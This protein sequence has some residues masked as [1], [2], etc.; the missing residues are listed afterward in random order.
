MTKSTLTIDLQAI[1]DN[2]RALDRMTKAE[3]AAVVKADSYGLGA[4][5]V[6]KT[7]AEAGARQFFVALTEEGVALRQALGE[8]PVINVFSGHMAGDAEAI[9]GAALTPM[10]NSTEQLLRQLETLP[11]HAFGIQLD[12]GMN[13]LGM[14]PAEWAALRDIALSQNPRLIMSHLACSDAPDHEMNDAQLRS[15]SDMTQGVEVPRS[16]SATGG[17]LLGPEYHFDVTRPGIGLY[18]GR[19]F[20]EARPVVILDVPV[21]QTRSVTPG[22]T[23]GYGNTWTAESTVKLATVAAG[24]ADGLLRAMG[25]ATGTACFQHE[26]VTL[27]ILGRVSM[28]LITVDVSALEEVPATLQLLGQSQG[29]DDLADWAGTIGYEVLTSLGAR[30]ARNYAG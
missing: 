17:I 29:I 4:A 1:A 3:T 22:E 9:A 28:D 11:G 18:G 12:S 20:T 24:Y 14:E 5:R 8:G 26:G 21:I 25:N 16:L 23:V 13:R 27:P 30:Y 10:I 19:P 7:L 15:F 2:W 6:A